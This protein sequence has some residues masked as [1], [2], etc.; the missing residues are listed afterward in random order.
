M[1]SVIACRASGFPRSNRKSP[2]RGPSSH[3]GCSRV[4]RV[5]SRT[6][7]GSNQTVKSRP[8]ARAASPTGPR[9]CGN[10]PGFGHQLP[11]CRHQPLLNTFAPSC[12]GASPCQPASIQ[13]LSTGMRCS[14]NHRAFAICRSAG[15]SPQSTKDTG[16]RGSARPRRGAWCASRNRRS[17]F[18]PSSR[19]PS[20]ASRRMRGPRICSPARSRRCVRCMPARTRTAPSSPRQIR[21]S[22]SPVQPIATIIPL[23]SSRSMLR[24]GNAPHEDLPPFEAMTTGAPGPRRAAPGLAASGPRGSTSGAKS[25]CR[26]SLPRAWCTRHPT[27]HGSGS[28]MSSAAT[29]DS[30]GESTAPPFANRATHSSAANPSNRSR[31][32]ETARPVDG[33]VQPRWVPAASSSRRQPGS[34]SAAVRPSTRNPSGGSGSSH[35]AS[36]VHRST[37]AMP[38]PTPGSR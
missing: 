23:P 10:S 16:T 37:S 28:A 35:A 11:T 34:S 27:A 26:H 21:A 5:P 9:P 33:S 18:C 4:I 20:H 22:Q 2:L 15:T 14:V 17:R 19:V 25:S 32:T 24:N 3:S 36:T 29:S 13:T 7:S 30:T 38:P 8:P 12:T 31:S 6:R 1:R